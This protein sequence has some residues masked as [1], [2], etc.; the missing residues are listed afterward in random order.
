[1]VPGALRHH[2][3]RPAILP[4]MTLSAA[5]DSAAR[6]TAADLASELRRAGIADVDDS[7]LARALY[8]S[9][10]SLYRVLPRAV[11]R[12]R[13]TDEIAGALEV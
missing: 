5:S 4:G 13:H 2:A 12:P 7:G 6:G 1:M 8:S 10:A 9:D 3:S 11:V